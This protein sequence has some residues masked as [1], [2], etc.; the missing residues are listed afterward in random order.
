MYRYMGQYE[1]FERGVEVNGQTVLAV[2]AGVPLVFEET[3]LTI[4]SENGIENPEL[5][6]WYSQQAWL[7]ALSQIAENIGETKILNIGKSIPKNAKW[8]AGVESVCD[9]LDSIGQAYQLN[10]RGG[11]I[12]YYEA[13]QVDET[14]V[15][16]ECK[17][18]YPCA[19]DTGILEA[20]AE[21]F[22]D[23]STP[24][25]TEVGDECRQEGGDTCRYEISW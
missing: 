16:V 13:E 2:V 4:L 22:A 11:D 15:T 10:H 21:E 24:T 25:V 14:T 23:S 7:D 18:P 17:N 12:G 20:V 3:A 8:P 19:F 6:E 1:A 9:G 5:D